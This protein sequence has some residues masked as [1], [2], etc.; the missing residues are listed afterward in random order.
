MLSY[1]KYIYIL[2]ILKIIFLLN[3]MTVFLN[4]FCWAIL[5]RKKNDGLLK[6]TSV[7][8][9]CLCFYLNELFCVIKSHFC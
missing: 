6:E 7:D 5:W 1:T 9:H 3:S 2:R 8:N 4:I